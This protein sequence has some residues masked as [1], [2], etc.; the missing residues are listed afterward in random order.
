MMMIV[1]NTCF[2]S[3]KAVAL[4]RHALLALNVRE[5]VRTGRLDN[6]QSLNRTA[7]PWDVLF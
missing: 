5:R 1:I 3:M 4:L 6:V 2:W 7:I